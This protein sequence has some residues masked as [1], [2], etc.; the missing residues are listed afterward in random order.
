MKKST[1]P[2][3]KPAK[4]TPPAKRAPPMKMAPMKMDR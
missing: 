2:A 1:P 4:S 3:K